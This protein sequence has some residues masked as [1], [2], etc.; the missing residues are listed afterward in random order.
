[1][2]KNIKYRV[3][4][5][6]ESSKIEALAVRCPDCGTWL[7]VNECVVHDIDEKVNI[8]SICDT[9]FCRFVCLKCGTEFSNRY[10]SINCKDHVK[11]QLIILNI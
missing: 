6:K 4:Y 1:M 3:R 8:Q 5:S 9:N 7:K 11:K 10:V 2:F